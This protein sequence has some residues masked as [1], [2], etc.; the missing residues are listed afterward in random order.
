VPL[1]D[2]SEALGMP[3]I[4]LNLKEEQDPIPVFV[5]QIN[6]RNVAFVIREI[7]DV[8]LA[9][10]ALDVSV[11]DRDEIAG[12]VDVNHKVVS[13]LDLFAVLDKQG[14]LKMLDPDSSLSKFAYGVNE[15]EIK[16]SNEEVVNTDN[17]SLVKTQISEGSSTKFT[18]DGWG[19][20]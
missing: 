13:V 2:L 10:N 20:F 11:R 18:G 9:S 16:S 15:E 3:S 6:S 17:E 14:I 19:L 4:D 5:V 8:C 7:S 1:I 12:T